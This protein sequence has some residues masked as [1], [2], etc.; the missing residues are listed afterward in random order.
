MTSDT[1]P[2]P[3]EPEP[4]EPVRIDTS[5]A[6]PARM[7]DYYLGGKD[8][9]PADREAAEKIISTGADVREGART[10]RAF[11][12]RAVRYLSEQGV[13]QFLDIGT[14]IPS[15]GNTHEV[16]QG[17]NPAARVVYVDNDPIVLTHARALMAGHGKGATTVVQADLRDP[18]ALL[19]N[20]RVR[21]ALDFNRPIALMLVSVLHF[22]TEE[23]GP[24]G[25]LK[26]LG[27]ALPSG[28]HLVIS[29]G[30]ADAVVA[31]RRAN[32]DQAV[33]VYRS[34]STAALTLRSKARVTEFF[35]GFP[36]VEPGLVP[37]QDWRPD[38]DTP[39]GTTVTVYAGVGRKP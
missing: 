13:T 20:R 25:I 26:T 39:P 16:A 1:A 19:A 8:N 32:L 10:N 31:R 33:D 14:G 6:H 21:A 17:I 9:F 28:S 7:Y 3:L 18:A 29:H 4:W 35:D 23:D 24:D 37:G 34:K 30:T 12:G 38:D 5:V 27:D 11:L 15:A 2:E 22:I 36:L